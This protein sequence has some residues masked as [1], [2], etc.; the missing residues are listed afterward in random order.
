MHI[1]GVVKVKIIMTIK[2]TP[3]KLVDLSFS[4]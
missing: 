1:E 3:D 2:V 4:G